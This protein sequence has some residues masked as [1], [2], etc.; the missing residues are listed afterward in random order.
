M[1]ISLVNKAIL[2]YPANE[3]EEAVAYAAGNVRGGSMQFKAYLDKTLKN[4]WAEGY[5]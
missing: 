1:V 2:D 3:V 5:P 4:K